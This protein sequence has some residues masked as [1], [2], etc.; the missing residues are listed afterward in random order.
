[1]KLELNKSQEFKH[2]KPFWQQNMTVF[3]KFSHAEEVLS[4]TVTTEQVK[5]FTINWNKSRNKVFELSKGNGLLQILC[6]RNTVR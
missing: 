6:T 5:T 2:V 1:M 4:F 3:S